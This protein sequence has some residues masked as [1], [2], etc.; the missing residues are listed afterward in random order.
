MISANDN[1]EI[2]ND[3][4]HCLCTQIYFLLNTVYLVF[5]III[6][7]AKKYHKEAHR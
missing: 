4:S 3:T 5:V 1:L 6:Q 7:N 2:E